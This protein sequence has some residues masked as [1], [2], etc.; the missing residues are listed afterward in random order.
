VAGRILIIDDD[1]INVKV[2]GEF[3]VR[4]G[5]EVERA[6]D[7][8]SGLSAIAKARPDL[9]LCDVL[10]PKVNGLDLCRRIKQGSDAPPVFLMSAVY[11]SPSIQRDAR[12]EYGADAYFIKPFRVQELWRE[13]EGRLGLEPAQSGAGLEGDL[14]AVGLPRLLVTLAAASETGALRLEHEHTQKTIFLE[15]GTPVAASSNVRSEQVDLGGLRRATDEP[16]REDLVQRLVEERVVACF[17]LRRGAF[18]F[19]PGVRPP[20]DAARAE[21]PVARAVLEGVRRHVPLYEISK[22]IEKIRRRIVHATAESTQSL[23]GVR[24][25]DGPSRLLAAVD[26][27]RTTEQVITSSGLPAAEAMQILS[28]FL[29]LG[30]IAVEERDAPSA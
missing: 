7:G 17:L 16:P 13:I 9:I 21:V 12:T 15:R 2:L 25:E 29:L 26:G 4:K 10:L 5:L 23:Y 19:E 18:R 14:A 30:V 24:L 28:A 22:D 1:P 11:R 20:A 6:G 8:E 27:A 3:L